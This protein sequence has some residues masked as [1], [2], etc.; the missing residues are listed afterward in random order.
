MDIKSKVFK[1]QTLISSNQFFQAGK[2]CDKLIKKFPQNTYFYNLK[3]LILQSSGQLKK[4][5][6]YFNKALSLDQNNYAAMNNLATVYKN[7]YEFKKS[8][9]LYKKVIKKNPKNIKVLNNYSN[10]KREF[11][12]YSEAK[13]L[14][15]QAIKIEPNNTE[16]LLNLSLCSQG[17]GQMDE[18]K[19]YAFKIIDIQ[20][21]NTSAHKILSSII[22]YNNESDHFE[23]MK[24]LLDEKKLKFFSSTEKSDLFFAVG[25]AYEDIKDFKNAYNYLSKANLIQKQ[26]NNVDLTN[27]KKLFKNL[28][29]LFDTLQLKDLPKF[30]SKKKYIFICGMPR[31][32][33]TLIEQI[34]AS[35]SKVRGAG[36]IHYLSNII[37]EF[38]L[39]DNN[40]NKSKILEELSKSNNKVI[41]KYNDFLNFHQFDTDIVTDKAPQNFIWIGFIKL[42]FPNSKIIHCLRNP[43]DNCLSLFK[44]HF[45]SKTMFW[46]YD[47]KDIAEYYIL[48]S[49][50]MNYWKSKFEDSVFDANYENLV[51][52]PET[53]V[54]KLISFCDLT[55][56]PEC[57]NFYQNKKTPVQTVSVS[58]ANKPIYKSSVNSNL[59]FTKHLS[60]MFNIL[61][62]YF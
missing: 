24:E 17:L 56:E 38:F 34:L 25:K 30:E 40:F 10:F 11:N 20:P 18:A 28:I 4:S 26:N 58:Q 32:G 1:I 33:T 47:Q 57:L 46:A 23:K 48:Y 12:Q 21:F 60:K 27:T 51:N 39:V 45:P 16:V 50:I 2:I 44:N 62:S 59:G 55:W 3:G 53:E 8:E 6:E 14:L 13:K 42:F 15:L 49:K 41:E 19:N 9:D 36:E 5:I 61:D 43:K 54:R 7:V 52:S 35:H 37:D 29:K 22:N 31:S